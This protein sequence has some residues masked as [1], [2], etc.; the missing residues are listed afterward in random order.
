MDL[1]PSWYDNWKLAS[2][3]DEEEYEEQEY[4]EESRIDEE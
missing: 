4:D 2:P 1:M 3:Y